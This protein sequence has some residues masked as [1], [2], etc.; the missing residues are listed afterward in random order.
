MEDRKSGKRKAAGA[1]RVRLL[2]SS[3]TRAAGERLLMSS[4]MR[5]SKCCHASRC[6]LR[7]Q[8]RS[9][10]DRLHL[11]SP[12]AGCGNLGC[13]ALVANSALCRGAATEGGEGGARVLPGIPMI[14]QVVEEGISLIRP[15]R[16]WG[17]EFGQKKESG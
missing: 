11:L 1:R 10:R 16:S 5:R 4:C 3:P 6:L 8:S 14:S 2:T 15:S 7:R 13:A 12:N 9:Q 17:T